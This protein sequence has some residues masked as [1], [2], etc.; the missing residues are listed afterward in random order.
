[1]QNGYKLSLTVLIVAA[2]FVSGSAAQSE[3]TGT[4]PPPALFL[5]NESL[6]PMV[7]LD[8]GKP[9]GIVVDLMKAISCTE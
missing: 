1:M 5:G 9:A 2:C 4:A 7:Y 6:P 3:S 8:G